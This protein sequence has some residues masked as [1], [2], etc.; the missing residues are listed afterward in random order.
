MTFKYTKYMDSHWT[1]N[2]GVAR[3]NRLQAGW[4]SIWILAGT[5]VFLFFKSFRVALGSTQLPIHWMLRF[6]P[7]VDWPGHKVDHP[8]PSNAEVK[9]EW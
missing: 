4:S 1:Q 2:S 3:V 5:R 9:N 6:F 8:P 7:E